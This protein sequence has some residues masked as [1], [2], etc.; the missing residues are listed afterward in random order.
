MVM[1]KVNKEKEKAENHLD[2]RRLAP[3]ACP[4]MK[5]PGVS[6]KKEM[7]RE[8]CVGGDL[9]GSQQEHWRLLKQ[10]GRQMMIQPGG[11]PDGWLLAVC[12]EPL[13]LHHDDGGVA[14][15]LVARVL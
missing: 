6:Q 1:E 12:A 14:Q 8:E 7:G 10:D 9:A 5:P 4:H 13:Q 2:L 3:P 15:E 11:R